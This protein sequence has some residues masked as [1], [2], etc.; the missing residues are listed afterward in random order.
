M[1]IGLK[2]PAPSSTRCRYFRGNKEDKENFEPSILY[3]LTAP[4][5]DIELY[6]TMLSALGSTYFAPRTAS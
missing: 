6:C 3:H 5:G 1:T 2:Q 4:V